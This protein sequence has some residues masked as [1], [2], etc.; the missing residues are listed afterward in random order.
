MWLDAI[1]HVKSFFDFFYYYDVPN[2]LKNAAEKG[3]RRRGVNETQLGARCSLVPRPC[4]KKEADD[5]LITLIAVARAEIA[6]GRNKV[7]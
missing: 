2:P 7:V 5:S 6:A 3:S 1:T 4:P